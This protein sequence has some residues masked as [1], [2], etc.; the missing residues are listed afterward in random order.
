MLFL[1]IIYLLDIGIVLYFMRSIERFL[2]QNIKVHKTYSLYILYLKYI[3]KI[4]FIFI[5]VTT[6]LYLGT[7]VNI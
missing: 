7:I 1:I 6:K 5:N 2:S 3:I 4:I